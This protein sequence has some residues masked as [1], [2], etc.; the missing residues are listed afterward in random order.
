VKI[1]RLDLLASFVILVIA[2]IFVLDVFLT[3]G[4]LASFDAPFH[5]TNIAQFQLALQDGDFPVVW[6]DGVANYGLPMSI[7]AHQL[8]NYLGGVFTFFTSDPV[9]SLNVLSFI[10]IFLSSIFYYFFLRIYFRPVPAFAATFLY[11]FSAYK[12]INFYIRGAVPELFSGIFLP[13]MLIGMYLFIK[14]DRLNGFFLLAIATFLLALN[15]PMMLLIYAFIYFPYLVFLLVTKDDRIDLKQ[16]RHRKI[17]KKLLATALA[18]GI[19]VGMA[20]YY[21]V[22]LNLEIKYFYYGLVNNHLTPNNYLDFSDFLTVNWQYFT[23]S[24][25]YTRGHII[26]FGAIESVG[27]LLG[28]GIVIWKHIIKKDR[29]VGIVEYTVATSVILILFTSP[30]VDILYAN[31]SILSNIQFPWRMLSALMFLAPIVYAY[32]FNKYVREVFV[33]GFIGIVAYMYFPQLYGKNYVAFDTSEY[34]FTPYN[35]HS[36]LMNTIWSGKTEEYPVKSIKPAVIEGM[37]TI[38]QRDQRNSSRTY[39]INATTPIRMVD[40]TFYFPGWK[41]TVD[42]VEVPIEF[43]DPKYRGVITYPVPQGEHIVQLTFEDTKVRLLGKMLTIFFSVLLCTMVLIRKRL[44]RL[45]E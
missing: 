43:Q 25:V 45:L 16:I 27:L 44:M 5:I 9:L 4:R 33:L 41:A 39:K 31:I 36:V 22:P 34:Y 32:I 26:Q 19:G 15:H 29:T 14:R 18:M 6:M 35:H 12:I 11:T 23:A 21:I 8:T 42:G 38:V 40:Y 24:E 30:I 3:P 1:G 28:L 10:G 13:L 7:V 37:G 20:S 2:G 17:V